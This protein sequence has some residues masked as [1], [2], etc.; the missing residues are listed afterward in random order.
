MKPVKILRPDLWPQADQ[1]A[2]A[3]AFVVGDPFDD[4]GPAAH[5]RPRSRQSIASGYGRWIGWLK[6]TDPEALKLLPAERVT[7]ARMRRFITDLKAQVGPS[8]LANYVKHTYDAIRVMAPD[9]DWEWLKTWKSRLERE[10]RPKRD[11]HKTPDPCRLVDLGCSLM[12]TAD[13][14]ALHHAGMIR[15]RDGLLIMLLALRPFRRRNIADI[16]ID[17]HLVRVG[18]EWMVL[19][20]ASE[21]KNHEPLDFSVPHAVVPYLERYLTEVR[22]RFPGAEGHD[23]LWASTRGR[24]LSEDRVYKIIC[25][26]TQEA[27][28]F[29]VRPHLFREAAA[30]N[31]AIDDPENIHVAR[32]L[33]GH[34]TIGTTEGHYIRA[35]S[36]KS[37]RRHHD[38]I[39]R[40]RK[41]LVK[42]SRDGELD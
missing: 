28:G 17:Q 6:E 25:R 5:W 32:D 10:M 23:G 40:M 38:V 35:N 36:I 14:N 41:D 22:P 34:K 19:H 39:A 3:A 42:R 7:Q 16:R 33:L 15:F 26:R 29:V 12:D 2:W 13:L 27:F 37:G 31:I 21:T 11:R 20:D 30:T 1:V 8:G 9:R 18:E 24:P 4:Q